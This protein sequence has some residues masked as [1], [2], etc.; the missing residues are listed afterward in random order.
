[1]RRGVRALLLAA[2]LLGGCAATHSNMLCV[3]VTVGPQAIGALWCSP[4]NKVPSPPVV[5]RAPDVQT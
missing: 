2:L 4:T 1:M 3:P 5:P